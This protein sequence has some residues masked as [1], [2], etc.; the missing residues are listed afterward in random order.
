[1]GCTGN[2][3]GLQQIPRRCAAAAIGPQTG[4]LAKQKTAQMADEPKPCLVYTV[5]ELAL[6][7]AMVGAWSILAGFRF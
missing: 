1:M 2:H 5:L 6:R 7:E 4:H 3:D